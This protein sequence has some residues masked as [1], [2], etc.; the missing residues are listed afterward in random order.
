MPQLNF[1]SSIAAGG[2]LSPFSAWPY[3]VPNKQA[4]LELMVNASAAG[5]TMNLT[6]GSESI[7][8]ID[9]PVSGGGAAGTLPARLNT[10][11][12][13]DMV[14]AS[15]EIVLTIKNPTAGAITVNGVAVVTF[16]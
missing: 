16:K 12:I 2:S 8:A 6:T 1:T 3:R 15:E 4:L 14:A 9:T 10:E 7:V 11:P 13:A 5:L